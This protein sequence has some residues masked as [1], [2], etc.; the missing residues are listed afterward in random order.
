MK[1]IT[2]CAALFMSANAM[3]SS[4][5]DFIEVQGDN[6]IF[7][8][9]AEKTGA[10]PSC[11]AQEHVDKWSVSLKTASGRALYS[12]LATSL[13]GRL[14]VTVTSAN[15]CSDVEGVERASSIAVMPNVTVSNSGVL[16]LFKGDGETKVGNIVGTVNGGLQYAPL[17]NPYFL[18][19]YAN[20]VREF[21]T[22][23]YTQDNCQG[24]AY[25]YETGATIYDLSL[26]GGRFYKTSKSKGGAAI[27]SRLVT[28][29]ECIAFVSTMN[30]ISR[31]EDTN[32]V[33]PLCG[34]SPCQIKAD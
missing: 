7:T 4:K 10:R 23:Y 27:R 17:E 3:A 11:V 31:I 21:S 20:P 14:N 26:N 12:M 19:N 32:Y 16:A 22:L 5:V 6:V 8:T 34:E 2:Y 18:K 1:Y 25:S 13:A 28:N 24:D 29:A 33:D 15:D 30:N 9:Q